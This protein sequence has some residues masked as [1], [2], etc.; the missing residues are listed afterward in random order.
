MSKCMKNIHFGKLCELSTTV[1]G[2][3]ETMVHVS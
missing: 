3:M 2:E 1:K